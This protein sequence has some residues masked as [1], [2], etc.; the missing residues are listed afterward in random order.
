MQSWREMPE[1][2]GVDLEDSEVLG[3]RVEDPPGRMV[4]QLNARVVAD[5]PASS[6]QPVD[7]PAELV[8]ETISRIEGLLPPL[9]LPQPGDEPPHVDTL[10]YLCR[11]HDGSFSFDARW[12]TIRVYCDSVHLR[13]TDETRA[14]A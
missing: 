12:G 2:R 6:D 14:A 1:F 9:A 13:F 7:R 10:A 8:L 11:N 3:W 5:R 4:V